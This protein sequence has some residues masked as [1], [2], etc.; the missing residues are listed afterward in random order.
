MTYLRWSAPLCVVFSVASVAPAAPASSVIERFRLPG[1]SLWAAHVG[2]AV[3]DPLPARFGAQVGLS[4]R[5]VVR[6][7]LGIGRDEQREAAATVVGLGFRARLPEHLL[8]PV[9]GATWV[10][11]GPERHLYL[12]AG[13]EWRPWRGLEL[14]GGYAR[15]FAATLGG[16]PYVTASWN[17]PL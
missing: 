11:V 8:S 13:L 12:A 17:V 7:Q 5:D 4:Y 14:G 3:G 2:A 6:F 15:S 9:V 1:R 16:Q 10:A